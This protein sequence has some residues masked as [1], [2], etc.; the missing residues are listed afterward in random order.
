MGMEMR[1]KLE[2]YMLYAIFFKSLA[3]WVLRQIY[4]ENTDLSH[5]MDG[6]DNGTNTH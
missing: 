3:P 2:I 4:E 6:N 5:F 1:N